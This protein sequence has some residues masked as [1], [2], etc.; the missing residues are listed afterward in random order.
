MHVSQETELICSPHGVA[1]DT[2]MVNRCE[3]VGL[4][5][6]GKHDVNGVVRVQ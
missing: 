3:E 6:S 2:P 4:V 5:T 1:H